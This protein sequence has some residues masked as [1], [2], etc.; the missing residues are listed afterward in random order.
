MAKENVQ[1]SYYSNGQLEWRIP[2]DEARKKHG[3]AV[4]RYMS[5][6]VKKT[7]TFVHGKIVGQEIQYYRD[8]VIAHTL[9]FVKGAKQGYYQTFYPTGEIESQTEYFEGEMI[10]EIIRWNTNGD[11]IHRARTRQSQAVLPGDNR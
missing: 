11:E 7:K 4:Q 10:G 5:G 8:G 6:E 2:L 1:V 3:D 9:D